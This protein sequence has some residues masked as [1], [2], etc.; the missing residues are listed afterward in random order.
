MSQYPAR[1]NPH[2]L[3]LLTVAAL[4]SLAGT[5][6]AQR[7]TPNQTGTINGV[8]LSSRERQIRSM[9]IDKEH[10]R[11]PQD[12]LAEINEDMRQLQ[13]LSDGLAHATAADQQVDYKFISDSVVEVKKRSMRL[14]T[15]LALPQAKDEKHSDDKP[16]DG[17][18]L[19]PG[20]AALNKLIDGFLHNPIFSDAGQ[21]DPQLAAKAKRDLEQIIT[22]SDKLRKTAD[23]L[24]KSGGK[25]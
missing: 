5:G 22:L 14:N 6:R 7:T 2:L 21:P 15:N 13:T 9:E 18:Q 8:D 25:N 3:I 4:L 10:Q 24:N 1:Y 19:Q 16:A 12:I 23:K 20:V 11:T 17:N